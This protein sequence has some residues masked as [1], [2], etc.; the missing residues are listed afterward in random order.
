M[1]SFSTRATPRLS[2]AIL[3]LIP[4]LIGLGLVVDQYGGRWGQPV[5]SVLTWLLW[6]VLVWHETPALRRALILCLV[7]ATGG[8]VVLSLVWGLYDYRL[9]NIPLFV[10]PGHV[11]LFWFGLRTVGLIPP[12]WLDITALATGILMVVLAILR[13]DYLSVPLWLI[14]ALCWYVGS[15]R[16]FYT[17]MFVLA[18]AMELYATL[19]GNWAWRS[20]V[21]VLHIPS[22]NPPLAAGAFYCM[23]DV[24]VM[25]IAARTWLRR[26]KVSA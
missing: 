23:L 4:S 20:V 24:L 25:G 17:W 6:A 1:L 16:R 3:V 5:V 18:L 12:R 2:R 15:A 19:L 11:L 13:W 7:L 8:E 10:P 22:T 14:F 9:H 26:A 21:P